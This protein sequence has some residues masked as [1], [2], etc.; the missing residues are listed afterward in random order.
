MYAYMGCIKVIESFRVVLGYSVLM[1]EVMFDV[2]QKYLDGFVQ[3][4]VCRIRGK[5]S[6][7][8]SYGTER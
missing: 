7:G 1:L 6:T 3:C 8:N 5:C 4:D 2:K